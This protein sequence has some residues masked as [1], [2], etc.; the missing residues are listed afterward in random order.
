MGGGAGE[1]CGRNL[2]SVNKINE[3]RKDVAAGSGQQC[4]GGIGVDAL[5]QG[6]RRGGAV[7]QGGK[8][9]RLARAAVGS[10]FGQTGGG[11]CDRLAVAG[12]E[13]LPVARG[14]AR[15]RRHIGPHVAIGGRHKRA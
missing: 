4:G 9:R 6:H 5:C 14:K 11:V 15:Q 8:D 13:H 10:K 1:S 3:M 7:L 12:Q 2:V